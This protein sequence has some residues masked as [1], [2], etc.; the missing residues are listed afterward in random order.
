VTQ[1]VI[2]VGAGFAGLAAAHRL[3]AAGIAVT[4]LE[5]SGR[6]GG[7]VRSDRLG[8]SQI[9]MGA[10]F[11]TSG[12]T[13]LPEL[14]SQLGLR[15][16]PM[17]MSFGDREPRG[18]LPVTRAAALAAAEVI[19]AAV[20]RGAGDGRSFADLVAA[21]ELDPAARELVLCRVA[22]SYAHPPGDIAAS[23]VR[24]VAHLFDD[25]ESHRIDGGN[26]ALAQRLA[27]NLDV[28]LETTVG[29]IAW[30]G[31][32]VTVDDQDADACVLTAP[33]PALSAIAFEPAL[34]EWKTDA[35]SRVMYGRAAKLFAALAAPA[36]PG[37]VM[38]VPERFWTWT[39]LG[40]DGRPA[41]VVSAFA[42]SAPAVAA[43]DVDRGSAVYL[44]RVRA[45]RPDLAFAETDA[46]LATWPD[47]AYSTKQPGR[48]PEDDELLGRPCGAVAFAGEHTAGEWFG[49]MEGAL[50]SGL[51]AADELLARAAGP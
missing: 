21:L 51:R 42:G 30:N 14:V 5:R 22:V 32:R 2:V 1:R 15:L 31:D 3:A 24:D 8:S 25:A 7:R 17:G 23:A 34:P 12:Y 43:L 10:E 37:A 18:G 49:T 33:A 47:G 13:V 26:D 39:A 9:E 19:A 44:G 35:L 16:K 6:V 36:V 46:T 29:R 27:M 28:R 50:R 38:S 11:V 45:L 4:V 48:P 41:T 40:G 20:E